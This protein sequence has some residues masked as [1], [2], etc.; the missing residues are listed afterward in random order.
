M[1]RHLKTRIIARLSN[2]CANFV[3]LPT[4][5][6]PR[7]KGV[8]YLVPVFGIEALWGAM[9]SEKEGHKYKKHII[10]RRVHGRVGLLQLYTYHFPKTWSQ[11]CQ[12]NRALIKQAQQLAHQME[13]DHSFVAIEWRIRFFKHYYTVVKGGAQPA[14]DMKPYSRFYQYVYVS[15]Y[16][17]LKAAQL[18]A[19]QNAQSLAEQVSF[20][21]I[22]FPL[23]PRL[24]DPSNPFPSGRF[25]IYS[26]HPHWRMCSGKN[27]LLRKVTK[28]GLESQM[29]IKKRSPVVGLRN[30][31]LLSPFRAKLASVFRL[32]YFLSE[33]IIG[34]SIT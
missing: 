11:A 31:T 6:A 21:P 20:E 8:R 13:R 34:L 29:G 9:N 27:V 10:V 22:H 23:S 16:R 28:T 25:S 12:D 5:S 15:I 26:S 1:P 7:S 3:Q 30:I 32:S 14:P 19:T 4:G 18:D 17:S 33:G 24:G 2:T